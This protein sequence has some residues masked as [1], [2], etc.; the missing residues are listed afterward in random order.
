MR[1]VYPVGTTICKSEPD[2]HAVDRPRLSAANHFRQSG[3]RLLILLFLISLTLRLLLAIPVIAANTPMRGDEN[4]YVRRAKGALRIIKSILQG[5]EISSD[6]VDRFYGWGTWGPLYPVILSLGF[7]AFG[8]HVWVARLIVTVISALTTPL[9]YLLTARLSSHK[10]GTV[11][12]L[13]HLLHPGLVAFAHLLWSETLFIFLTLLAVYLAIQLKDVT[14]LRN[15]VLYAILT[16]LVLGM[17]GLVRPTILPALFL[18]PLWAALNASEA[19]LRIILPVLVIL[20][21]LVTVAPWELMLFEREGH[22]ALLSTT[23]AQDLFRANKPEGLTLD[24]VRAYAAENKLDSDAVMRELAFQEISDAPLAAIGRGLDRAFQRI[25]AVEG[26]VMKHI[27][28]AIYPPLPHLAVALW[29]LA[30]LVCYLLLAAFA[31][32]GFGL[33]FRPI[34]NYNNLLLLLVLSN[35]CF[36]F[37]VSAAITRLTIVNVALILPAVGHGIAHR[38]RFRL[39]R[40]RRL[41][42]V[43]VILPPLMIL[44]TLS[45]RYPATS[46]YYASLAHKQH[47]L[48]GNDTPVIDQLAV[49]ADD[50][51]IGVPVTIRVTNPEYQVNDAGQS[52]LVWSPSA[53]QRELRFIVFAYDTAAPAE[54]EISAGDGVEPVR[55]IPTNCA[56]WQRW[57]P[58]GLEGIDVSWLPITESIP[59]PS[60]AK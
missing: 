12:A 38:Q 45:K 11:A 1:T 16:G 14:G 20:T 57:R 35:L 30:A 46:G 49:R 24:D 53:E 39:I 58:S 48:F 42:A 40:H 26:H 32:L 31:G 25:W 54:L 47:V 37:V 59:I 28:L 23:A 6:D 41:V 43:L 5:G 8:E 51:T 21:W 7:L 18:V 17:G 56:T 44:N 34:G 10:A 60:P 55:L 2:R 52:Q 4:G 29:F 27:R 15:G 22:L 9:V 13:A 33:S 3:A 19:R 36:A 50:A